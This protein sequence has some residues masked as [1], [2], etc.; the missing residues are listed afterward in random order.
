MSKTDKELFREYL[1]TKVEGETV[2]AAYLDGY[3]YFDIDEVLAS[4]ARAIITAEPEPVAELDLAIERFRT[5]AE[6]LEHLKA[7]FLAYRAA[8][9]LD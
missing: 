8:Q 9:P 5:V 6:N 2:E 3:D 7:G 1:R 4:L